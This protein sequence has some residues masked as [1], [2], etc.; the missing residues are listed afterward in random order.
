MLTIGIPFYNNELTLADA[1]KSVLS[2]TFTN[3]QLILADDGSKDGSLAVAK[4]FEQLD[5]RIKVISDG[6]NK[7]ISYRLNLIASLATGDY[8]A[9]M[10]ADDMMMPDRLEKQ[11]KVLLANPAIDIIDTAAYVINEKGEPVGMRGTDDLSNW[12]MKMVLTKGL[13]FH[14]AV[15]AKTS[16]FRENKYKENYLRTEDFELWCRTFGKTNFTRIQEPLFIYREG[17]VNV[18]NYTRSARVFREVL[19]IYDKSVLSRQEHY[20]E[21]IKSYLKSNLYRAFALFNAHHAL[22]SARNAK[23]ND[24]QKQKLNKAIQAIKNQDNVMA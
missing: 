5:S 11:M 9:R 19:R 22:S 18:K 17:K 10:D 24:A 7:G 4:R 1:V 16:W 20:F 3:W 13:F 21:I 15:V 14:P 6:M 23:L 12:N 8:I 2:Q